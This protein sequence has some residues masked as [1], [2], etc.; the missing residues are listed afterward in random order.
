[1]LPGIMR[2][3]WSGRR[4]SNP[5]HSAWEADT[6]PTELLPLGRTPFYRAPAPA[7]TPHADSE[8]SRAWC[9][10]ASMVANWGLRAALGCLRFFPPGRRLVV[11]RTAQDVAQRVT[12]RVVAPG[13]VAVADATGPHRWRWRACRHVDVDRCRSPD[14]LRC[15]ALRC[16]KAT[17]RRLDDRRPIRVGRSEATKRPCRRLHVVATADRLEDPTGKPGRVTVGNPGFEHGYSSWPE[18]GDTVPVVDACRW[19]G[20]GNHCQQA[21]K[22]GIGRAFRLRFRCHHALVEGEAT[23]RER[24]LLGGEERLELGPQHM[25]LDGQV[26]PPCV[27]PV[28][29]S[30]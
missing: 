14:R 3:K 18:V 6:L 22:L 21:D 11:R 12:T 13:T 30:I 25:S 23:M 26:K 20:V 7:T 5:R 4:G 29:A 2:G 15:W 19:R 10:R 27:A 28:R 9:P 17:D 16:L 1:M 24:D 8:I